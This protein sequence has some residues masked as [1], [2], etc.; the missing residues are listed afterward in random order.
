MVR[1]TVLLLTLVLASSGTAI[2]RIQLK[3]CSDNR[4][5]CAVWAKKLGWTRPQCADAFDRCMRSGEW[6]TSGPYGR[7]VR[8]VERR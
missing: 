7:T 4:N 3:T 8:N 1:I 6:H 2:A 5:Y